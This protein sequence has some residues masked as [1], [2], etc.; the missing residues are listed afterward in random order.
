MANCRKCGKKI[1]M[2]ED[3][4]EDCYPIERE[5]EESARQL[6]ECQQTEKS[7]QQAKDKQRFESVV[8]TTTPSLANYQI[9]RTLDIVTAECVYGIGVFQDFFAGISDIFGGRSNATQKYL[10]E[11]RINCLNELKKEAVT[12]GANAVIAVT[13]D[14]S[15]FSGQGKS[16]LFLVACG[17]AVIVEKIDGKVS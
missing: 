11:A 14:Y 9:L 10:R 6:Y 15:E 12:L 3:I 16:M 4:C 17:T 2:W 13:L 8:L 5:K 1:G 7:L